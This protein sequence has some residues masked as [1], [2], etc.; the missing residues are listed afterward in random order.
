[1]AL[2]RSGG[3]GRRLGKL[4][5][6]KRSPGG[7]AASRAG[8][9]RNNGE[10]NGGNQL[11]ERNGGGRKTERGGGRLG[12]RA[13]TGSAVK[14]Q[15]RGQR[16]RADQGYRS[17]PRGGESP[18]SLSFMRRSHHDFSHLKFIHQKPA[19]LSPPLPLNRREK[20]RGLP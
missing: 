7:V 6:R 3:R 8:C 5:V 18:F 2:Q 12:G 13:A 16:R 15:Q 11:E 10:R 14:L 4:T 20:E 17:N 19:I 1:M 9:K